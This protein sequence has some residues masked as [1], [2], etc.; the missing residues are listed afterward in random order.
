MNYN[1]KSIWR[2]SLPIIV[3][4]IFVQLINI[5]DVI[6][7]GRV[8]TIAVGS[9]GLSGIY[10]F[11]LFMLFAGFGF[12]AQ[13]IMS[14]RNGEKNYRDIGAVFY[15]STTFLL[16]FAI[17]IIIVS[18]FLS[19][20]ILKFMISDEQ[21]YQSALVYLN[22]R[23]F[24]LIV[25]AF[26]VTLRGFFVGI[27]QTF[28]LQLISVA[29]VIFNVILN[30]IFIFGYK[31]IPAMGIKGAAIASVTSDFLAVAVGFVYFVLK[32]D[33]EKYGFKT[34]VYRNFA[35]LKSILKL[36]VWTMLQQFISNSTWFL[37]FAAVEHLGT[38]ELAISN[39]LR[40]SAGIPWIV[41]VAFATAAGTIA[42]NLIGEGREDEV[43]GANSKIIFLNTSLL[44]GLIIIFA[45]FYYPILRIF[46]NNTDLIRLAVRPY[47][48]AL[49]CYFP[50]FSGMIWFQNVSATGN[51]KYSMFIE[52]VAMVFYL[53][54]VWIVIYEMKMPLYICM[55]AD[56]VYN[57]VLFVMS[58]HF[59]HSM[60][61]IGKKV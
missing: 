58:R 42:G 20:R 2:I 25:A 11:A 16:L 14:R 61:W 35:L 7:L 32:I 26:L 45:F 9:A 59:M 57:A 29:M 36:S 46:T 38:N 52:F 28:V 54:F 44:V 49:L 43:L 6:F 55:L 5:T 34:F 13:I 12:G 41:T 10:F 60:R 1:Y 51:A 21:V 40:N 19:P 31:C 50:L 15:Q 3:S 53:L 4:M 39:I 8:S 27:A 56:G 33:L 17:A 30:Y 23:I 47:L 18:Y 24:G 37:F 22:W 48:T